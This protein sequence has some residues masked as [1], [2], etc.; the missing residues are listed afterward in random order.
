MRNGYSLALMLMAL[1]KPAFAQVDCSLLD[2]RASVSSEKEGRIQGSIDT[3][4]K[5]AKAEGSIEAKLRS[6][7]RN[8]QQGTESVSEKY[9]IAARTIFVFCG[10]VANAKDIGTERKFQLF[11][12]LQETIKDANPA[13]PKSAI[14]SKPNA[15]RPADTQGS[16]TDSSQGPQRRVR[17]SRTTYRAIPQDEGFARVA[18]YIVFKRSSDGTR[19]VHYLNINGGGSISDD[20]GKHLTVVDAQAREA[21]GG[22]KVRLLDITKFDSSKA[23]AIESVNFHGDNLLVHVV[24]SGQGELVALD[25]AMLKVV[26]RI[27]T[28]EGNDSGQIHLAGDSL[29]LENKPFKYRVM[30]LRHGPPLLTTVVEGVHLLCANNETAVFVS[31]LS[32]SS[33]VSTLVRVKLSSGAQ[34]VGESINYHAALENRNTYCDAATVRR[35]LSQPIKQRIENAFAARD[36]RVVRRAKDDVEFGSI[37]YVSDDRSLASVDFSGVLPDRL[38]AIVDTSTLE[39]LW[40]G[41]ADFLNFYGTQVVIESGMETNSYRIEW[42]EKLAR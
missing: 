39:I 1:F 17:L 6:E 29:L 41:R 19:G 3:L 20:P 5:V 22:R 33:K 13:T 38:L 28:A 40:Q 24:G 4:Y 10:M 15:P 12:A 18:N 2:P 32:S 37:D 16:A 9:A 26:W 8:L 42:W 34:A 27:K 21:L 30:S 36:G 7:I 14:T 35:E 11:Q 25:R 23:R 31:S